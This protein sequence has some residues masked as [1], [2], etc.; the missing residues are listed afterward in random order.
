MPVIAM[1]GA[2]LSIGHLAPMGN[3]L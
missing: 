1:T 2:M 3:R